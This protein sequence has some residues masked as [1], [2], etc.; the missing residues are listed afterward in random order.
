LPAFLTPTCEAKEFV[1]DS[2]RFNFD[3]RISMPGIGLLTHYRGW[4]TPAKTAL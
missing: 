2:G 3:V 4:L 1:D